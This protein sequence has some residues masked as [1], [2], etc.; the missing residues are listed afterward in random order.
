MAA[1][2]LFEQ[3]E[4]VH[5][6]HPQIGEHHVDVFLLEQSER[7][8]TVGGFEGGIAVTVQERA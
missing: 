6:R 1:A 3:L 8:F 4:T 7:F 2:Y 5:A